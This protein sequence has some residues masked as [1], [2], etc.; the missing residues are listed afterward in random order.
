MA[1][2]GKA[3]KLTRRTSETATLIRLSEGE[4]LAYKLTV[5]GAEPIFTFACKH[6][7]RRSE[8]QFEGHPKQVYE[9]TWCKGSPAESDGDDD[10][11]VV[12]MSFIAAVKYT[13]LVTQHRPDGSLIKTLK[14]IDLERDQPTDNFTSSL[15]VF[16][17]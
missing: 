17:I 10:T 7:I 6:K 5:Q 3:G 9:W 14:D 8:H 4:F 2:F 1:D 16:T 12:A 15:G 11:Y 13:L